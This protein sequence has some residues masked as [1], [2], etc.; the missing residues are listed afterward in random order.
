MPNKAAYIGMPILELNKVLIYE[1]HNGYVKNKCYNNP[2]LLFTYTDILMYENK[3]ENVYEEF[4]SKMFD[5]WH[6][7]TKAKYYNDSNKLVIGKIKDEIAGVA[8]DELE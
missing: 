3:T 1:F 4:T 2:R 7:L 8:I 5:F 6:Y